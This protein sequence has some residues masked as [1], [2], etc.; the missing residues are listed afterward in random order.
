MPN[1]LLNKLSRACR[2]WT[3]RGELLAE[4]DQLRARVEDL[5]SSRRE[6]HTEN[7]ALHAALWVKR[8][9]HMD[10][11]RVMAMHTAR[12]QQL[13]RIVEHARQTGHDPGGLQMVDHVLY[14]H[15]DD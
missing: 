14:H 6:L 10:D 4:R 8:T 7:V 2:N 15:R 12:I 1:L 9:Q 13:S 5:D 3:S 11:L